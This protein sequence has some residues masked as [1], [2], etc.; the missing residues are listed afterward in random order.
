MTVLMAYPSFNGYRLVVIE[1]LEIMN[2][3]KSP[4]L[5]DMERGKNW[6]WA[7]GR[8]ISKEQE[9]EKGLLVSLGSDQTTFSSDK[10]ERLCMI[11]LSR[12]LFCCSYDFIISMLLKAV[13]MKLAVLTSMVPFKVRSFSSSPF[14]N[15]S[16]R[17]FSGGFIGVSSRSEPFLVAGRHEESCS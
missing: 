2:S 5:L 9:K 14:I 15:I 17:F 7:K 8:C 10:P 13:S 6:F 4:S 1:A 16:N 3:S 12:N 11:N